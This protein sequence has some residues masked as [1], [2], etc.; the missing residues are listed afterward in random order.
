MQKEIEKKLKIQRYSPFSGY[1]IVLTEH[2]SVEKLRTIIQNYKYVG[3]FVDRSDLFVGK[4]GR[5]LLND[6]RAYLKK[7]KK[8]AMKVEYKYFSKKLKLGRLE[9]DANMSL[10]Q[11]VREV[12][13]TITEGKYD[14]IDMVN[15]QPSLLSWLCKKMKIHHRWLSY[16]TDNRDKCLRTLAELND[17]SEADVKV[18]LISIMNGG[19]VSYLELEHKTLFIVNFYKEMQNI[20]A[21]IMSYFPATTSHVRKYKRTQVNPKNV[22]G[23]TT[24]LILSTIENFVLLGICHFYKKH[25]LLKNDAILIYDGVMIPKNRKN[26]KLL[27]QCEQFIS[28][29]VADGLKIGLKIKPPTDIIA[30]GFDR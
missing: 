13:S 30:F 18:I 26:K 24:S 12:R 8:G 17:I 11:M 5:K 29:K 23:A 10:Q 9:A 7:S 21:K 20:H 2:F 16:Y 22:G 19:D 3:N 14:D 25:G 15:A 1:P 6:L 28:E 27:R 4:D